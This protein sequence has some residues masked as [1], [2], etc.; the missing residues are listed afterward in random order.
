MAVLLRKSDCE[1]EFVIDDLFDRN[2]Y[3]AGIGEQDGER[4][5]VLIEFVLGNVCIVDQILNTQS[6]D[7]LSLRNS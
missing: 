4:W 7:H 1:F 6:F 2:F 5:F 3:E